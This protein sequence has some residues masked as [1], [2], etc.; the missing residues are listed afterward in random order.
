VAAEEAPNLA[1]YDAYLGDYQLGPYLVVSVTREGNQMFAQAGDQPF[2]ELAPESDTKFVV[3][4]ISGIGMSFV[5]DGA[6]VVTGATVHQGTNNSPAPRITGAQAQEIRDALTKR[7]DQQLPFPGSE[8][9]LKRHLEGV[10]SGKP[11]YDE[12][13]PALATVVRGAAAQG[14]AMLQ[15]LGGVQSIAFK[16]V[17]ANGADLFEVVYENGATQYGIGMTPD[18]KINML[19]FRRIDKPAA[20]QK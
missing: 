18:G 3:K 17:V 10:R 16:S 13:T 19:N 11:I 5:K 9:A 14:Q 2:M 7:V 20:G 4:N 15:Q 1:K 8:S 12:M 6:G